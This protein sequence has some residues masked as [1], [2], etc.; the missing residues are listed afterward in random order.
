MIDLPTIQQY[1][2]FHFSVTIDLFG[3][4]V[5]SNAATFYANGLKGRFEE[6]KLTDDHKLHG[7]NTRTGG[8]TASWSWSR[9]PALTAL[10][11]RLRDDWVADAKAGVERW[12]R[13]SR[14]PASPSGSRA[15][16]RLQPPHR[17]ASP[18]PHQ[19]RRQSPARSRMD[20]P[21]PRVA[22]DGRGPRLRR[23]LM[24]R[25][26]EPGK[27]ANWIAPPARGINNQ[28]ADFEYVRFN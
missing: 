28:P 14:R 27:F 25:V 15:R 24:G 3:S 26:A 22:A 11:E 6:T 1:L 19:P 8:A 21:A 5:S 12:N 13:I 17:A 18:A 16:T 2:N 20:A 9:R 7:A 10:N 4:E 23:S